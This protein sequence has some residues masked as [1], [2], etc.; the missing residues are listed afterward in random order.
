[1]FHQVYAASPSPGG[2]GLGLTIAKKLVELQGGRMW[3][4]SQP[5][6]GSVFG[7][8]LPRSGAGG[9]KMKKL[10]V[11]DDDPDICQLLKAV[12]EAY[13]FQVDV[14]TNGQEALEHVRAEVPDGIFLDLRMPVMD[15]WTALDVLRREY[16]DRHGHCDHGITYGRRRPTRPGTRR[17][18]MR[19]QTL[20]PRRAARHSP[21]GVWLD[22]W[23]CARLI[24]PP[25]W[26][27]A[28]PYFHR[29]PSHGPAQAQDFGSR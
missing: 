25:R 10:L 16:P 20:R 19:A 9:G 21:R 27:G 17:P 7:F 23:D 6:Q 18:G 4:R 11:V 29:S 28:T 14:A 26:C 24:A 3:V 22:A 5:G 1:M 2:S 13:R 12:L 15:G 8:A